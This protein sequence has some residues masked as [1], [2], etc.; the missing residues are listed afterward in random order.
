VSRPVSKLDLDPEPTSG[1]KPLTF[2]HQS[3]RLK[4]CPPVDRHHSTGALH[5]RAELKP[6]TT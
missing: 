6:G 2:A 1:L 4:P 3:A 5:E